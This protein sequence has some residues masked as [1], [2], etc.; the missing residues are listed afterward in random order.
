M[1]SCIR[2]PP[3][4]PGAPRARVVLVGEDSDLTRSLVVGTLL[5]GGYRVLEAVNGRE[6]LGT[7]EKAAVDLIVTDLEMPVL[8]GF[9]L[10]RALRSDARHA[11]VPVMV[12]TTR[13]TEGDRR[14]AADAGA[15]V[16]LPK[17][18]FERHDV[19]ATV[20]RLLVAAEEGER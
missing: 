12:F 9:E 3:P 6:A 20:E 14:R 4:E 10:I 16:Y 2:A 17:S 7:L 1:P 8:D 19:L 11:D 18:A 15:D 13:E 5:D